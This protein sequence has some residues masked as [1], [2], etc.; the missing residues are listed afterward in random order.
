MN[1][2]WG[3]RGVGIALLVLLA[4]CGGG[5]GGDG[6]GGSAAATSSMKVALDTAYIQDTAYH[7][8]TG[9]FNIQ[10]VEV[11]VQGYTS[12]TV[13]VET[14]DSGNVFATQHFVVNS[15][16]ATR[17]PVLFLPNTTLPADTYTG[18]LQFVF[19]SDSACSSR[20]GTGATLPY[21]VGIAPTP[22]IEAY[23][24]GVDVGNLFGTSDIDGG[25]VAAGS[26]IEFK[27]PDQFLLTNY[28]MGAGQV[29]FVIDPASV[30]GD[31][32]GTLTVPSGTTNFDATF[33]AFLNAGLI[34]HQS[35]HN[36]TVHVAH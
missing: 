22:Q 32:K 8:Q 35:S 5:G 26:V 12:G 31:T 25:T 1:A 2:G 11:Y 27:S 16:S 21:S 33:T 15:Q 20:L 7:G 29:D 19:C 34:D 23:V 4:S 6:G 9:T 13:Y 36:L 28:P 30:A 17:F 24:N 14:V 18:N 3:G 10:N